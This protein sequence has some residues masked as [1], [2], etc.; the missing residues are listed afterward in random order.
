LL[1]GDATPYDWFATG[2]QYALHGFIDDATGKITGLHMAERECLMEYLEV[3]RT[4]MADYGLPQA[5]YT[6]KAG[7]FFVHTKK[8][9]NGTGEEHLAGRTL[10]KTQFRGIG[11]KRGIDLI[12][13]PTPQAKGRIERLEVPFMT[14]FRSGVS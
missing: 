9:E 10:D 8:Q 3:L 2:K 12:S 6:D 5:L 1:Q 4:T 7:M 11:E 14:A 13:T